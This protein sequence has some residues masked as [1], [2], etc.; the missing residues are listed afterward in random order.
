LRPI[1]RAFWAVL[2][3][4]W[5]GWREALH[6]V[7]PA[8]VLRWHRAGF[9]R[10]WTW[11]SRRRGGRPPVAIEVR[12][13]VRW[14]ARENP[15]WGAPR[16]HGELRMLG[17]DVSERTV[18]RYLPKRG[19][20]GRP[21]S[22]T[23]RSFLRNHA[24]GLVA[25]DFFTVPSATFQLL[26]VLVVLEVASRKILHF[27]VTEH[28]TAQWTSRQ[29]VQAC[30]FADLPKRLIRD[31]DCCYG[32]AFSRRMTAL[33]IDEIV[34]APRSPWQ[35]GYA[36][37]VIG[38]IKRECTNHLMV[39]GEQHLRR[40]LGEYRRYYNRSRTHLALAK[41]A[42]EGRSAEAGQGRVISEPVLGGLHHVYRRAA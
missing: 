29:I 36:E 13:L 40:I 42:P 16:I 25:I 32:A 21:T 18:A 23:W 20:P 27:N 7:T 31:R 8:T 15:L 19:R 38:T 22:P 37:R 4:F 26:R 12:D 24:K 35:N 9:A 30:D 10:F 2:S 5:N 41:D 39:V 14:L 34:T 17:Y 33:G 6:I 1:D 11:R 28:P 3:R